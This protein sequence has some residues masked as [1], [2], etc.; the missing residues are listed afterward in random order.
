M[1]NERTRI[2]VAA[3]LLFVT[4]IA[5]FAPS[6]SFSLVNFDDPV[7]IT[8]NPIVANGFSWSSIPK[9]F[10]ELHGDGCMYMPLL[11]LSFLADNVFFG[12]SPLSPWGFHLTNVLLHAASA[13]LLFFIL[14][15]ATHRTLP[16]ILAAAFWA[17]HPLRVESVA[18]VTERK[19]TL[20]TLFAFASIL[21]YLRAFSG[22]RIQGPS[23]HG[24]SALLS[25]SFLFFLGGLL[26]KPMLITLPF[27]FL[28]LDFW[29]LGRF[30]LRDA[31]HALPRLAFRKW[32]FFL[33]AAAAAVVTRLLQTGA[34]ADIP[35]LYRLYWLPSNYLFYLVKS[36]WPVA[37]IPQ[38][39]GFPVT[40][41]FIAFSLLFLFV[42]VL[43]ALLALRRIPGLA[44][45][46]AAFAGILF[47]VSGIVFIGVYPV[48]D[49][50][51]YLPAFG[52][53]L[54][55]AALLSILLP[56]SGKHPDTAPARKSPR[57]LAA[58]FVSRLLLPFCLVLLFALAVTTFRLLPAWKNNEALYDR[59]AT[60][61][62]DH[63]GVLNY[64]FHVAF[65]SGRLNEAA[66]LADQMMKAKPDNAH[67]VYAKVLALSQT[68]S[69]QDALLFFETHPSS[70]AVEDT[71]DI[72]SA[73][74]AVLAADTSQP[75]T[76]RR[77]LQ[78]AREA[79]HGE[80]S[81]PGF[82]AKI[83]CWIDA[84]DAPS[85]IPPDQLL[86]PATA[87]WQCGLH[88]QALP[89][90]LEIAR[91]SPSN[92]N[93]LNNV[94]WLLATTPGSPAAPSDVLAIARTARSQFP[95]HPV[96]QDTYAVACAYASRFEE[97]VAVETAVEEILRNSKA[98]GAPSM[99]ANVE[100]RAELFRQGL[101]YT[102]NSAT[103]LLYAAAE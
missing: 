78:A 36:F 99:L 85:P 54:A 19:D 55:L 63:F 50:Y 2:I 27:L 48:A 21:C 98:P 103:L 15:Q 30:S 35:L 17:F 39:P 93:L 102:E 62:P 40:P 34:V 66:A 42:L 44:V 41:G 22:C 11:W 56:P 8:H 18:W 5:L 14:R 89:A 90:L 72:L 75:D 68:A 28:L 23:A 3:V 81:N 10:T 13:V 83:A 69:S 94:A 26:S 49:R 47:P 64:R 101:P 46:L 51:S 87:V 61:V 80:I 53:S 37:L 32:P 12:A 74:L 7:F 65:A 67:A 52:L 73:I 86:L 70:S 92:P 29:P 45:G 20:S 76:A 79:P 97:A 88:Q 25:A 16:A 4:T 6:V 82:L 100:K 95:S 58:R 77:Y 96:I 24:R 91:R 31:L 9:A 60:F 33:L 71:Q 57:S 59:I 1:N 38:T 84:T 43:L